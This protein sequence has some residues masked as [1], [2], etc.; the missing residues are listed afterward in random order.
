MTTSSD[1]QQIANHIQ[2]LGGEQVK[3]LVLDWLS[4]TDASLMDFERLLE[5]E[6]IHP[7]DTEKS[8]Y[9]ELDQNLSFN[10]LTEEQMI[11]ASLDALKEYRNRGGGV[12]HDRV[13]EWADRLGTGSEISCPQ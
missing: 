12:S 3:A 13:R 5:T 8:V 6:Y 7:S 10:P 2:K 1:R 4:A 11:D 9:G